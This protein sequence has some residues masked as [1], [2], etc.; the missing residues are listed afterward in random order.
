M[1]AVIAWSAATS[2]RV[3]HRA[4]RR[5]IDAVRAEHLRLFARARVAHDDAHEEAIDL[6]LG[7]RIRALEIDRVLRREHEEGEGQLEAIALDRDLTLLHRLEQRG[8][9]LG[10]RAVDLVGEHD[11]RED[12]PGAQAERAVLRREH[13]G[14]GDVGRAAGRA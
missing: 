3:E 9:R 13:V 12:R 8:L 4:Q 1:R 10:G 14:A 11:V 7:Q 5:R 6:R 2:V